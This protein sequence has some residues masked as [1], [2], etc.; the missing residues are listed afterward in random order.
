MFRSFILTAII[1]SLIPVLLFVEGSIAQ[2]LVTALSAAAITVTALAMRSSEVD[3]RGSLLP[4]AVIA[5]LVPAAWILM[6]A[7]PL[8]D[9]GLGH[10]IWTSAGAALGRM[11]P[12]SISLDPG[13][14]LVALGRYAG[15]VAFGLS[16]SIIT[17]DR[18]RAEWT[19]FALLAATAAAALVMLS[20]S[21]P[22]D[23]L[24]AASGSSLHSAP[25]IAAIGCIIAIAAALRAYER[26][27]TRGRDPRW[28][29]FSNVAP[30]IAIACIAFFLCLAALVRFGQG[31]VL[32]AGGVGVGIF[33]SLALIRRLGFGI[34]G[35]VAISVAL[36][37]VAAAVFSG[38]RILHPE[39][40]LMALVAPENQILTE[41]TV[42]VLSDRR[43]LGTG[44][45]TF[46]EVAQLYRD[47]DAAAL[48]RVV[49]GP[50]TSAVIA[51]ELGRP[52][53]LFAG[54]GAIVLLL[55]LMR[56]SIERGRD[57]FYP[58]AGAASLCILIITSF[59]DA[60]LLS[61]SLA[62]TASAIIGLAIAQSVGRKSN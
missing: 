8:G 49:S 30:N 40:G 1:I 52:I 19:L 23:P 47:Y 54:A 13:V 58:A 6:Q 33:A 7:I 61:S 50:T 4:R 24:P 37:V 51:V 39:S 59:G 21:T 45:G 62:I 35:F 9:I 38:A 27:E 34:W 11:L 57:S 5:A 41:T 55:L 60:D 31:Y 16:V 32:V 25:N 17:A 46:S 48:G 22:P 36:A 14:T 29:I 18:Q 42:R 44:A 10:P 43:W 53:L 20:G 26:S 12:A 2:G 3:H 56:A 28:S 15:F